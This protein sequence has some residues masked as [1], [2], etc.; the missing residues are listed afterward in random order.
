[1]IKQLREAASSRIVRIAA[2]LFTALCVAFSVWGPAISYA[3]KEG[4]F[5]NN[6]VYF[7]LEEVALSKGAD[8]QTMQFQLKLNNDGDAAI[9]FNYFG[10]RV[11]SSAGGSY[12]AQL[13]KQADARVAGHSAASYYFVST[14]PGGLDASQLHVTI[15]ERSGSAMRDLG[16]L[17]V[18]NAQ[19]VAQQDNKLLIKLSDVDTATAA[20]AFVSFQALKAVALPQDGKWTVQVDAAVTAAGTDAITLPSGL[21]YLLHDGSGTTLALTANAVEGASIGA[22]QTKHVL[23]TATADSLPSTDAMILD[24]A[25]DSAGTSSLGKLSLAPLFQLSKTGERVS[26]TLHGYEGVTLELQKAEEQQLSNKKGALLTAVLHNDGKSTIKSPSLEGTLISKDDKLS[27][28]ASTVSVPE[29]YIA[30]GD[31]GIYR[32]AAQL[33]DGTATGKLQLII[34]EELNGSQTST[35]SSSQTSKSNTSSGSTASS[36]SNSASSA[37]SANG[38]SGVNANGSSS[39]SG[40]TP[41][42]SGAAPASGTGTGTGTSGSGSSSGAGTSSNTAAGASAS[43]T[44]SAVPVLAVALQDGLAA[45]SDFNSIPLYTPGQSLVFGAG[46]S[47]LIDPN[48][49][50][51]IVEMDGHTN[52]ENGYRTV[53]A[54]FKFLNKSTE[55]LKLP[56]FDTTL[57]DSAGTSYPGARQTTSLQ[58]LIPNAA[59]VYSYS[60]MLPPSATDAFK[61]SILDATSG[62]SVKV[63]IG[64]YKVTVNNTGE[65]DPHAVDKELDLYPFHIKMDAWTLNAQYNGGTYTYKL[66]ANIDIQKVEQVIVDDSFS[67]LELEVVDAANRVLGSTTQKLQGTGK[68]ISGLQTIN[69]PNI[70][71]EQLE[72][73]VTVR[74]YENITTSTGTARRLLA[75]LTQ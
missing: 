65:Q 62:S 33:P 31:A 61:L 9:D 4:V 60:Y 12:Y 41:S 68:L 34:A 39:A 36:N 43:S 75:T 59:Y 69:F 67:T 10:A 27:V 55:T 22:G 5:V 28:A 45:A 19:S 44:A 71:S 6:A 46:S 26:Y 57:T 25:R 48:L 16:A 53:V 11:T 3:G 24:L 21:K 58:E 2:I 52:A 7:T 1:M 23:L 42:S 56:S 18:A 38:G 17:S 37:G 54:K 49:D 70:A 15:F 20:N 8:N 73:P 14:V 63:P 29:T 64:E 72:Y 50:V 74:I 66:K 40:S 30:P 51:S 47:Q 35:G 13:S 32:F